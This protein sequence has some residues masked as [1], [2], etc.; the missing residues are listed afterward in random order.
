MSGGDGSRRFRLSAMIA[1][2][3]CIALVS[4]SEAA[5]PSALP[6]CLAQLPAAQ[7][8]EQ[9]LCL[10]QLREAGPAAST[11]VPVLCDILVRS[12]GRT[13]H[14]L[15]ASALD[16]LRSMGPRA[17]PA[18]ETLSGL[19][20]HRSRLYKER[21]KMLVVRLRAY[22]FVT[23]SEI[24]LPA[25]ALPA[26][27]DSLAH[28]DERMT[29]LEVAAA[30]RAAGSLGTRGRQS[31]PFLLQALAGRLSAEEFSLERYEP[32]FPPQEATTVQLEIVRSLARVCSPNHQQALALLR[33]L[34]EDRGRGLDPRLVRES[35]HALALILSRTGQEE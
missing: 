7:L 2:V 12:D 1:G 6:P 31:A 30:A 16:V 17:A 35:R 4:A 14:V 9:L 23:L 29:V 13:D 15:I 25:S 18:A 34:G 28:V 33:D 11:A 19:L 27:F 3:A 20:S 32:Q 10:R 5:V 24:G 22:I 26:L 21:D 8:E